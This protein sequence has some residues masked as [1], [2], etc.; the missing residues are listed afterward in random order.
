MSASGN[1]RVGDRVRRFTGATSIGTRL[2]GAVIAV[3]LISLIIAMVV[4]VRTGTSLG[5][6][7][8][9]D[10]LVALRSSGALDVALDVGSLGRTAE[11][12]ASSRQSVATLEGLSAAHD[13]LEQRPLAELAD[14]VEALVTS[15]QPTYLE[16]AREAGNDLDLRDI[17]AANA[18]AIH[19][20]HS[21]TIDLGVIDDPLSIDDGRDG[22]RW[23]EIHVDV[24]PVYR[25]VVERLGL[26]DLLLVDASDGTIVYTAGKRPDLGTS[27]D[28]G[29]FSGS[30]VSTLVDRVR[31]DPDGGVKVG[32][33]GFYPPSVLSPVS[34][35][36]SPILDGDR[37]V[38]VAVLTFEASRF[39]RILSADGDWLGFPATGESYLINADGRLLTDPRSY[40]E[41]PSG[42]LDAATESGVLTAEQ[43]AFV[44]VAGTTVLTQPATKTTLDA[45]RAG[46]SDVDRRSGLTGDQAFSTVE[47]V[48]LDDVDWFIVSE[49]D[50]GSAEGSLNDFVD[51][52]V[53]GTAIFVVALAFLAVAWASRI[54]RPI[55]SISD[56][57]ATGSDLGPIDVPP[58]SPI[59]FRGL[60]DSFESMS[61]V[62]RDQ[63][64]QLAA[65]RQTRLDLLRRMLPPAVA[66]R[67]G[68]GD[69]E[70]FEE[71]P[72]ATIV[73]VVVLGLGEI[74]R[75]G[76]A[77]TNRRHMERLLGELDD[78][79]HRHGVERVKVVGDV[80]VAACGHARPYID[81]VPRTVA[82]A[83]EAVESLHEVGSRAGFDLRAAIGV[84]TGRVTVGV[85]AA[86]RLL[87]DVWGEPV[88]VAHH[89]ARRAV[90]DE[91]L[92]SGDTRRLLPES[93]AVDLRDDDAD[94]DRAVWAVSATEAVSGS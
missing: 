79:A 88:T 7:L 58:R 91:I 36:A 16:P 5:R 72:Q 65:A 34:A 83:K 78:I 66:D 25:Q 94:S 6:D 31:D 30:I 90:A 56:R 74:V 39:T 45:A 76:S 85:T 13:E 15:Y 2:P 53:V 73:A 54:A 55:R 59:E 50:I 47:A 9:D 24:H 52:L 89:L 86:T 12:L 48:D 40:L 84:H 57:L 18:A 68:R 32:D 43:A 28:V 19:L 87:Y 11:A 77:E 33:V 22:S 49:V 4:G 92:V 35:V 81:H 82:F 46:D 93:A 8:T 62:L 69:I 41:S 20:Q 38:G 42:H 17:V 1:R 67:V 61:L 23:S 70:S 44:R 71:V 64:E 63:R 3:S 60:A 37:L 51:L 26:F 27:L 80:Y 21:Y 29:P 14:E 75:E 10:R